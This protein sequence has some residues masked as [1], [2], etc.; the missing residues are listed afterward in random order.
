[1]TSQ[2][3][4]DRLW[5]FTSFNQEL[6][7]LSPA[8]QSRG[9]PWDLTYHTSRLDDVFSATSKVSSTPKVIPDADRDSVFRDLSASL[10]A[11]SD[12]APTGLGDF[13]RLYSF[14]GTPQPSPSP[15]VQPQ[16]LGALYTGPTLATTG[17]EVEYDTK[18][19][20]SDSPH[21]SHRAPFSSGD[22]GD[23][24]TADDTANDTSQGVTK[25]L[26]KTQRKK[27]RRKERKALEPAEA[28]DAVPEV[29]SK[30]I[31]NRPAT[32]EPKR[33]VTPQANVSAKRLNPRTVEHNDMNSISKAVAAVNHATRLQKDA[34]ASQ[35]TSPQPVQSTAHRELPSTPTPT[36]QALKQRG[37]VK[38][39]ATSKPNL[40]PF[41]VQPQSNSTA[42]F[43]SK[44]VRQQATS[45]ES[46]HDII[47]QQSEILERDQQS[48]PP[49]RLIEK[50]VSPAPAMPSSVQ[51]VK[52]QAPHTPCTPQPTQQITPQQPQSQSNYQ[53]TPSRT[54]RPK[55]G[56][57]R[58]RLA[59]DRHQQLLMDLVEHF[60]AD[61]KYLFNPMNL[62][63]HNNSP[64]GIHVF[65]DASNIF[66]GFTEQLK[67][68]RNIPAWVHVEP[69]DISFDA[70]AL[71]MERRRPVAKR[72]L[73]GSLP[74]TTAFD[75]AE[76][77]GYQCHLLDKVW[78][79]KELTPRQ[80]WFN[81]QEQLRRTAR[82]NFAKS[83][84]PTPSSGSGG[85]YGSGP[86]TTPATATA[87]PGPQY[88]KAKWVE[89]G[90]D[91]M[92]HLQMLQS[93]IDVEKPATMVLATG[94][95]AQAEYSDGFMAMAERALI[96]GWSVELVTWSGNVNGMYKNEAF[97]R[98]WGERF[99]IV[100]LDAFAEELLDL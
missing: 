36:H 45:S 26:T 89:Q 10:G 5:D 22:S 98:K 56:P 17:A 41:T 55:I 43:P 28:K 35:N 44:Q 60:P 69:A 63:T 96:K 85:G 77:V 52:Q 83:K 9:K 42:S 39:V 46:L 68:L 82:K 75:R 97:R 53:A 29:K 95:A 58:A 25:K 66:I 74:R 87:T 23:D 11:K 14:L 50:Q 91:E 59:E 72:Y 24:L 51:R 12:R 90:V 27:Q 4:Q 31:E 73:A 34:L 81:E 33:Q 100:E 47:A 65:V 62:T 30:V 38:A 67:K 16:S 21:D 78:K 18:Q 19:G 86:E 70:L 2:R 71:L 20:A 64:E 37:N 84:Y 13:S 57:Q 92:L 99:R 15:R 76:E 1:M 40:L 7:S 8:P 48:P 61:K 6:S 93:I 88:A 3:S 94:D 80:I 32:P 54:P 49:E 79:A